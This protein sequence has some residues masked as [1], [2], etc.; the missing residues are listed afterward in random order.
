VGGDRGNDNGRYIVGLI[1]AGVGPSL[2][3]ALHE[4]EADRLGLRYVY[5]VVDLD[6]LGLGA[7]AVGALVSE[8][9]RLGFRGL[10]ITHP[11]KRA[12]VEW[13]DEL[14]PEAET[15]RAVNTVVF[16]GDKATGYNTDFYGFSESFVRGLPGVG[17]DDVVLIGAG[18]AGAAV[19]HAAL[20][21]GVKRLAIL[22]AR[23]DSALELADQLRSHFDGVQIEA[24][25]LEEIGALLE[26]AD[27]LIH[28]TPM[29]MEANEGMPFA[30]ALLRPELWVADIVYRP[31]ET[32]LLR[33]AAE[34]GCRTLNGGGMAV[35]QAVESFRLFTGIEPDS[36][37]MLSH[38]AELVGDHS[39]TSRE[40]QNASLALPA[41]ESVA[42]AS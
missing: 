9:R 10:N 33:R 24:A 42:P 6:D 14:S 11:C 8:A 5:Q 19:A 7:A 36:D 25:P 32:E 12:V 39:Q 21:L 40:E 27:G 37:R 31:L 13:L 16:D 18:G 15:F 38:F 29:G 30:P 22:D 17:L 2:S 3:P 28:A 20:T 1:G 4:G 35:F 23:P 34:V 26:K 41:E